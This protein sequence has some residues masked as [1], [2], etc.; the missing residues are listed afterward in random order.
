MGA[1]ELSSRPTLGPFIWPLQGFRGWFHHFSSTCRAGLLPAMCVV[2]AACLSKSVSFGCVSPVHRT[3]GVVRGVPLEMWKTQL[4]LPCQTTS[5]FAFWWAC[6][7]LFLDRGCAVV[8]VFPLAAAG[9]DRGQTKITN[10]VVYLRRSPIK[11]AG[12]ARVATSLTQLATRISA[13]TH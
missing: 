9:F 3:T 10:G 11:T 13:P 8:V 7:C 1:S 5:L 12:G 6:G 4:H 2:M